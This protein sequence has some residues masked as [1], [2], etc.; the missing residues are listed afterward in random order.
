M[1]VIMSYSRGV[2]DILSRACNQLGSSFGIS[3]KTS[4]EICFELMTVFDK[5]RVVP[6]T[7]ARGALFSPSLLVPLRGETL[8]SPSLLLNA[9]VQDS[10]VIVNSCV[11]S[12]HKTK[13]NCR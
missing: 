11:A 8:F 12:V 1:S 13:G 2:I 9:Q 4:I 3:G 10:G 5:S 7:V 6:G